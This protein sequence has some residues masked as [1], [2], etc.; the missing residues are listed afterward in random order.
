M[1]PPTGEYRKENFSFAGADPAEIFAAATHTGAPTIPRM[2]PVVLHHGIFNVLSFKLGKFRFSTFSTAVEN[3]IA[4]RGHP[5]IISKVHP[6]AGIATRAA[7]LKETILRDLDLLGRPDERVIIIAHS[8]GGLDARHM[9]SCQRM[10]DRVAALVTISSPH[11]GNAYADWVQRHL[12]QRLGGFDLARHLRFDVQAFNDLTAESCRRF[13]EEVP[14][15][16]RVRYFSVTAARPWHKIPPFALHAW[17][18]IQEAEGDN[19]GLVSVSSA[20]WGKHLET[21]PVD[22]WHQVNKRFVFERN[23]IGNVAPLYLR[24]LDQIQEHG[25]EVGRRQTT[26]LPGAARAVLVRNQRI[27]PQM[28]TD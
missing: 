22:H 6:T 21:W 7:E 12:G 16:P 4:A 9:I 19:D 28:K 3:A 23:G 25:V 18:I 27:L 14:D 8:M 10:A 24:M 11:R 5:L 17:R 20:I 26:N 2:L 13:N 1:D 15:S